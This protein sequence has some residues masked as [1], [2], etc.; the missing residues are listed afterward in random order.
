MT[1]QDATAIR[2]KTA[3]VLAAVLLGMALLAFGCF[4]LWCSLFGWPHFLRYGNPNLSPQAAAEQVEN[5]AL[6]RLGTDTYYELAAGSGLGELLQTDAWA[7]TG[8]FS[9]Q[10]PALTLSFGELYELYLWT[11]GRAA[12]YD[13]YAPRDIRLWSYYVLPAEA[14]SNLLSTLPEAAASTDTPC[15]SFSF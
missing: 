3:R 13:G 14:V 11:D 8:A 4:W 10:D 9:V 7:S 1:E 5:G 12:V 6:I 2:R 15:R